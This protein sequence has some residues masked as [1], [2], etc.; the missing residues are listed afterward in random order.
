MIPNQSIFNNPEV[1]KLLRGES[2]VRSLEKGAILINEDTS[3]ISLPIV[4]KGSISI[5]RTDEEGRELLLYFLK[6]GDTC[7]MSLMAGLFNDKTSLKAVANEDSEVLLLPVEKVGILMKS[8]PEW[9]NFILRMYHNRFKELLGVI[10]EVTF[11]KMDDRLISYLQKRSQV[12]GL[13]K[14]ELT[15]EE[16][17]Q[18]LGTSRVVISRLLKDFE[19]RGLLKL[20]RN[21]IQ[22]L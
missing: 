18:E 10:E 12:S 6:T 9:I 2:K 7:V 1:A 8:H 3:V 16:I 17:A 19:N 11:K 20:G 21:K 14:L 15:H 5:Y 13:N 22:L 4:T